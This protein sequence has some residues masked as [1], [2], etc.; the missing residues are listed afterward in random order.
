MNLTL[1][2]GAQAFLLTAAL[3]WMLAA[4]APAAG[5]VAE[6]ARLRFY[7]ER[8]P[9]VGGVALAVGV[10][11]PAVIALMAVR[12]AEPDIVFAAPRIPLMVTGV[13]LG[14]LLLTGSG[15]CYDRS[16]ARGYGIWIMVLVAAVLAGMLGLTFEELNLPWVGT[17]ALGSAQVPVTIVWI[18][19]VVAVVELL[20]MWAGAAVPAAL[21]VAVAV[22]WRA[23]AGEL[24]VPVFAAAMAGGALAL[25]PA[26]SV[27]R[28]VLLGKSGNKA[29]GFLLAA[30]T[31]MARRKM[32]ATLFLVV[33]MMA[34]VGYAVCVFLFHYSHRLALDSRDTGEEEASEHGRDG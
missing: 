17:I 34:L 7:R 2:V 15:V 8:L 24:V 20:D 22:W 25:L 28:R 11:L 10:T 30:L 6:P 9:V 33:P 14:V 4:V 12:P 29:V 27:W 3:L 31:I 16:Q 32:D 23:A 1:L 21:L 5:L 13:L 19:L 18:V 26:A